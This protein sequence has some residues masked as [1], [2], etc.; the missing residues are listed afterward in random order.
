MRP[1]HSPESLLDFHG[2]LGV[3]LT[4]CAQH[5]AGAT[6]GGGVILEGSPFMQWVCELVKD[7]D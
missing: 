2:D 7:Q 4:G 6:K 3:I 5:L 1:P